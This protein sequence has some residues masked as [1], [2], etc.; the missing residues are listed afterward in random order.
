MLACSSVISINNVLAR[1]ES[2][3]KDN[4]RFQKFLGGYFKYEL[5]TYRIKR[6]F[7]D[8][9]KMINEIFKFFPITFGQ[10]LGTTT[11][12]TVKI[13]D[14]LTIKLYYRIIFID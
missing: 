4:M 14:L 1:F 3:S 10:R 12:F 2:L 11:L 8:G 7:W 5:S 13:F 9:H 6:L